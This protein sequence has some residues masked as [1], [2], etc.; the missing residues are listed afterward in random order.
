M[1]RKHVFAQKSKF[2]IINEYLFSAARCFQCIYTCE[3]LSSGAFSVLSPNSTP[4]PLSIYLTRDNRIYINKYVNSRG[5]NRILLKGSGRIFCNKAERELCE[6]T[7]LAI[8][9][10]AHG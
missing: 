10:I 3:L 1:N 8:A 5:K 4:P 7:F 9:R 6:A 2:S